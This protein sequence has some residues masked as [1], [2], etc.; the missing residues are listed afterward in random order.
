[1]ETLARKAKL[2][3]MCAATL[4][5][6]GCGGGGGGDGGGPDP[7]TVVKQVT[8]VGAQENPAVTTS[9]F[10]AG[11]ITFNRNTGAVSG[12]VTTTGMTGTVAHIH[13]G[14]VGVNAPIIVNMTQTSPGVWDV[15]AG[16]TLTVPQIESALAGNLYV[17]VHSAANPG[18]E[19]RA[20]IGRQVWFA[21]LTGAQETPAVTTTASGTG[22]F[23]YD[24]DTRTLSG[25]V[26]TS[27]VTGTVAHIHTQ[28]VGVA[29]PI[30]FPL[31]GG[32]TW[33]LAPTVLT[34]AQAADLRNGRLYAN[35]HSAANPAG[36]IRGQLYQPVR[37]ATLNGASEVP[38]VSSTG[39]GNC[40]VSVN[41]FNRAVAGRI[42][43][44]LTQSIAAHVHR[45]APTVAGP[46]VIGMTS[47]TPG[48][49]AIPANTTISD[50]VLAR[51]MEGNTYCNV[52][53]P[54]NPTGEI[55]GQLIV[56]N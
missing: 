24:P 38:P 29:G 2:L 51:F 11:T 39:S 5:A 28:D 34:E 52:H 15:V 4:V 31:T 22:R 37:T 8:L 50:E 45:G 12:R 27:G 23:V 48:N 30:T 47:P 42:E 21:T 53:T 55:R 49:W 43:S 46:V 33:T 35:V 1:M 54:A 3:V 13:E 16:S 10:G 26:T 19:I 44:T 9:A 14:P 25:T 6:A 32:P 40:W 17:N 41:P 56:P 7:N 18:G 36:E 20:Q